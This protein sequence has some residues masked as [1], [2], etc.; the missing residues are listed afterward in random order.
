MRYTTFRYNPDTCQYERERV[1]LKSVLWYSVGL[2][3]TAAVFLIG[4]LFLHDWLINTDRELALRGENRALRRH[5][6][7]LIAQLNELQPVLATLEQ[8]DK[9]LHARFFGSLPPVTPPRIDKASKQ[10]LLLAAPRDFSEQVSGLSARSQQL[11]VHAAIT[12]HHF[13][14]K[15]K[16]DEAVRTTLATMPTLQPVEPWQ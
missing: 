3:T 4:I 7:T 14:E 5:H 1:T 16:T 12:N 10:Q 9:V 2:F 11:R 8:K 15:L 6:A 13:S